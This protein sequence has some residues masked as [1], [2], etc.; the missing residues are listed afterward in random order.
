MR[1]NRQ[2]Q[3]RLACGQHLSQQGRERDIALAEGDE[4]PSGTFVVLEV[5]N[6]REG[7]RSRQIGG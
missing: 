4:A 5:Q 1:L 3:G 7:Q 6:A 2:R